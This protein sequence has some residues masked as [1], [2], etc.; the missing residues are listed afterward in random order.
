VSQKAQ[1]NPWSQL[2]RLDHYDT[3]RD[4]PIDPNSGPVAA[5]PNT[6]PWKGLASG[7]AQ[8]S[9]AAASE[10]AQQGTQPDK[11]MPI[12]KWLMRMY[13]V[14]PIVL[15]VPDAIFNF[16]VYTDGAKPP[17]GVPAA[18]ELGF[19]ALWS[20][21]AIGLVGMAY[22]FSL[23]APYHWGNRH[24]IQAIFCGIGL[25]V[26][27]GIT[28][29]NSLAYRSQTFSKFKTDDWIAGVIPALK[30]SQLSMTMII[31]AAA[32]PLWGLFWAIIQPTRR[33]QNVE[34]LNHGHVERLIRARQAAELKA[35]KAEV[36]ATVRAAQIKGMATTAAAAREQAKT[37]FSRKNDAGTNDT[38][39]VATSNTDPAATVVL[40]DEGYV[41][42]SPVGH[43]RSSASNSGPRRRAER[44][45]TQPE[46]E[47]VTAA[48]PRDH[49]QSATFFPHT[50]QGSTSQ[51]RLPR[52]NGGKQAVGLVSPRSG[53]VWNSSRDE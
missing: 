43:E 18:V 13:Y 21:V 8:A 2:D 45:T 16:Y 30:N 41:E 53:G 25:L 9:S 29:W 51:V 38:T 42:L 26:A 11:A 19:F 28:L 47:A 10:G 7:S 4:G 52:K 6:G 3:G 39:S 49:A 20:F 23:L 46:L 5:L 27:T 44:L 48:G 33:R 24:R 17:A 35:V 37:L 15:Y 1:N 22:M 36:N 12:P 14:F 34:E 50:D 32:P 31:V 40:P